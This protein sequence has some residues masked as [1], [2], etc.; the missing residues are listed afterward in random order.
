MT[1]N[2]LVYS[3]IIIESVAIIQ[4]KGK[5]GYQTIHILQILL[6]CYMKINAI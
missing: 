1:G 4:S 3:M 2:C 5:D 6:E